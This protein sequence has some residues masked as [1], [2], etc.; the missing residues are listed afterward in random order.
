MG[1]LVVV[2]VLALVVAWIAI[3]A[4]IAGLPD[5]APFQS[6]T[7]TTWLLI[8]ILLGIIG[9]GVYLI[10][11]RPAGV[12]QR[13]P[14]IVGGH[15][16]F[17]GGGMWICREPGCDYRTDQRS[18]AR[19]HRLATGGKIV[20]P[21]PALA[22]SASVPANG[23]AIG[24]NVD[25]SVAA[26]PNAPS[27][28]GGFLPSPQPLTAPSEAGQL[29]PTGSAPGS[30]QGFKTCPDCAEEVR[31]AARKCRFCGFRFDP[32]PAGAPTT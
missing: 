2:L 12:S 13:M 1:F 17:R 18:T 5:D 8:S 21:I 29:K 10:A 19:Q 3:I 32:A 31:A 7:K 11:G 28:D 30:E 23:D 22:S 20:Q 16:F 24:S 4:E 26:R 6:G 15:E 9:A 25:T 14:D 27:N